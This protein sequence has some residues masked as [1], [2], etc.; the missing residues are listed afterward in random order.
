MTKMAELQ[1]VLV[2]ESPKQN[3]GSNKHFKQLTVD[4]FKDNDEII[5]SENKEKSGGRFSFLKRSSKS[6]NKSEKKKESRNTKK[7]SKRG[8]P[9]FRPKRRN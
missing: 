5:T 3:I 1:L 7:K 9:R 8:T 4:D 2:L 6:D